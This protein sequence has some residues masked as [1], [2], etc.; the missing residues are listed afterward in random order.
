VPFIPYPTTHLAAR[1]WTL[2]GRFT[3]Y[4]AHYVALAEALGG[5]LL[6]GDRT[7]AAAA[8]NLVRIEMI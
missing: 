4:D 2:R 1:I 7:F 8:A 6:T 5:P 3:V